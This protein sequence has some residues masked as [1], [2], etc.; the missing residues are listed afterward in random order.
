MVEHGT[1]FLGRRKKLTME[2]GKQM[3]RLDWKYWLGGVPRTAAVRR[4]ATSAVKQ[5][6]KAIL[7]IGKR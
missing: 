5:L 7:S 6:Y 2:N 3:R 4:E 1:R